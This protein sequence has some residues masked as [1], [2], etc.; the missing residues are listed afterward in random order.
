MEHAEGE[1]EDCIGSGNAGVVFGVDCYSCGAIRDVADNGV[2]EKARIRGGK[3]GGCEALDEGVEAT[4]VIDVVVCFGVLVKSCV[5]PVIELI[6]SGSWRGEV[7]TAY[8]GVKDFGQ[9]T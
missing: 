7:C 2:K 6:V 4:L 8:L 3:V 1:G 5:L 9:G